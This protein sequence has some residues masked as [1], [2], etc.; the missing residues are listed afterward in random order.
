MAS[1]IRS[2]NLIAP[3]ASF[4]RSVKPA[5][6]VKP[7]VNRGLA[8]TSRTLNL[9]SKPVLA[10]G[11]GDGGS[12]GGN[13]KV[14]GGGG[15]GDGEEEK[16]PEGLWGQYLSL[17]DTNPILTRAVTCAILNGLGD[18]FCQIFLEGSKLGS[19]DAKRVLTFTAL[20]AFYVGPVLFYWY[21]FLGGFVTLPGMQGV[22]ASL[23]MDQLVFAPIFVGSF[24]A[25]L[26][27]L[28]G[29]SIPEVQDKLKRDLFPAVKV[30]WLLW[31]PAQFINFKFV[32][33]NLRV[34]ATNVTA[35]IWN[36][37]MSY[38]SHKA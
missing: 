8:P 27:A 26:S 31:V 22:I 7:L 9:R 25:I 30:N 21:S 1:L 34:L 37:Y 29:A 16:K 33:P 11:G 2:T 35:L 17:L 23:A 15:D 28:G 38:A 24:I 5:L 14:T 18:V 6:A 4:T 13:N 3:K 20:G 19:L 12:S 32:P 36:T 10:T